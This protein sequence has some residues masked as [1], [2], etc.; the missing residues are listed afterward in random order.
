MENENFFN[1]VYEAVKLIPKGKVSTY[2]EIARFLGKPHYARQV[3][4]ALHKNPAPIKVPCHR[5]VFSDGN[6]SSA[7]AFGGANEQYRLLADEGVIFI[8]DKVDLKR[9]LYKLI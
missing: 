1:Q 2:G 6:L 7:F 9:C 3:G 5:V 8:A 4:W